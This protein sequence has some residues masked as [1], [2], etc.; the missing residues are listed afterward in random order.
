MLYYALEV[1]VLSVR[2]SLAATLV[3]AGAAKLADREGFTIT[4]IAL[5]IS[6]RKGQ[7]ARNAALLFPLLELSLGLVVISGLWS[8]LANASVLLLMLVFN[9][10][11]LFAL[12]KA[13]NAMCQCF[14]AL[15]R[16]RFSRNLFLRSVA[17]TVLAMLILLSSIVSPPFQGVPLWLIP[18]L[19]AE[20]LVLAVVAA[21]AVRVVE[22]VKERMAS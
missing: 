11:I 7:L 20:F 22:A 16:T 8:I 6:A 9:G 18:V 13:P 15:S 17:L 21:H 12:R 19:I 2:A 14:G 3:V 4:L 1:V 10:V 5:G